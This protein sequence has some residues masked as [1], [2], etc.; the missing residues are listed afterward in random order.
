[1]CAKE[2]IWRAFAKRGL[3]IH[4]EQGDSDNKLDGVE[5]FDTPGGCISDPC[6]TS[7]EILVNALIPDNTSL[8]VRDFIHIE[9]QSSIQENFTV[10]FHVGG[11]FEVL[12]GS[13]FS[14]EDRAI[15]SVLRNPCD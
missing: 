5:S 10:E 6:G 13:E 4:A 1:M 8:Y 7:S 15:F 3:G 9:G 12:Q 11:S 14:V 2:A